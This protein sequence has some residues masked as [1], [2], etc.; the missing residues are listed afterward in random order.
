M[1]VVGTTM[2]I[3]GYLTPSLTGGA[4]FASLMPPPDNK[5]VK[6]FYNSAY[7]TSDIDI[8]LYGLDKEAFTQKAIKLY[9]YLW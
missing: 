8:Y 5:D 3:D 9:Q 1:L 6:Q 4:V 2:M 7:P